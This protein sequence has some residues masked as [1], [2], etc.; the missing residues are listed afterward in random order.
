MTGGGVDI[1]DVS[2]SGEP[3]RQQ[4]EVMTWRLLA[5]IAARTRVER[6]VEM[7]AGGGQYD[8]VQ[9]HLGAQPGEGRGPSYLD[10]NRPGR[11]H[12][13][14]ESQ[15]VPP[16]DVFGDLVHGMP[17]D[18]AATWVV[19]AAAPV[20]D[21]A[22]GRVAAAVKLMAEA[23]ATGVGLL[24]GRLWE[25]RNGRLDAC[26]SSGRRDELFRSVP[27]ADAACVQAPGDL[28]GLPEYRFWFLVGD[29]VPVFAIEPCAGRLFIGGAVFDV[30]EPGATSWRKV[31]VEDAEDAQ[32]PGSPSV[33]AAAARAAFKAIAVHL[34]GR[35]GS[36]LVAFEPGQG[37]SAMAR[38]FR[39]RTDQVLVVVV[40]AHENVDVTDDILAYALAWQQDRDLV[41]IL[42]ESHVGLTLDR[43]PWIE[44]PIRVF[45]YWS[46]LEPRPAI[47]PSRS[48][49]LARASD[50]PVRSAHLHD[51]KSSDV[52][53]EQLVQHLN[54]HWALVAAHRSSYLAWHCLGRQVVRM[55]R[56][57]GGVNTRPALPTASPHRVR[58]RR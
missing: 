52:L 28:L 16:R 13:F 27:G 58:S 12:V 10:C 25:W 30:T 48:E 4:T 41:L 2:M 15:S 53:V 51:L 24:D 18:D 34:A 55:A 36:D 43:L 1:D 42:P 45:T 6:I 20:Q 40:G 35:V 26:D 50:R 33:R 56:T 9:V 14:T 39:D 17:I 7:H 3:E 32:S 49:V 23:V 47:V 37:L 54:D 8:T 11:L 5:A 21:P 57:A 19:D 46:D 22:D 31:L 29:G 44:S 38:W